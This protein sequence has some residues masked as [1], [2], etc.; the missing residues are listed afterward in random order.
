MFIINNDFYYKNID[1]LLKLKKPFL[2]VGKES[3][4]KCDSTA[5]L[6]R[7]SDEVAEISPVVFDI[8]SQLKHKIKFFDYDPD[9]INKKKK[10]IVKYYENLSKMYY[11]KNVEF[12]IDNK[13]PYFEIKKNRGI[14]FFVPFNKNIERKKFLATILAPKIA[15]IQTLFDEYNQFMIPTKD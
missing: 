1:F 10:D 12:I 9:N 13:N 6:L 5:V 4:K 14:C 2:K 8:S 15:K 3:I 11:Y 7:D